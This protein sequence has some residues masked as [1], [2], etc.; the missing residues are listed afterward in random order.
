MRPRQAAPCQASGVIRRQQWR[1]AVQPKEVE[2]VRSSPRLKAGGLA[3]VS[4]MLEKRLSA[5]VARERILR[6]RNGFVH[7]PCE[8][9]I[10][11][12]SSRT[13]DRICPG[14]SHCF[15]RAKSR[16]TTPL[17]P[18]QRRPCIRHIRPTAGRSTISFRG[19][20]NEMPGLCA[21][22]GLGSIYVFVPAVSIFC[23][24]VLYN[25]VWYRSACC[26]SPIR[27]AMTEDVRP[28]SPFVID[29]ESAT[30]GCRG[31]GGKSKPA[32]FR[33]ISW[34]APLSSRAT[35]QTARHLDRR[36]AATQVPGRSRSNG[37]RREYI[38]MH[39]T[40][41]GIKILS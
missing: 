3:R 29:R 36:R 39:A 4:L 13:M 18:A 33:F 24:P 40:Q 26:A 21:H 30:K 32:P 12:R 37:G 1:D 2:C 35:V 5:G 23:P 28:S 20:L 22:I 6:S 38:M 19:R 41:L 17:I 8:G 14:V 15:G 16:R 34:V 11:A 7:D 25:G 31:R 27:L 9:L 10:C